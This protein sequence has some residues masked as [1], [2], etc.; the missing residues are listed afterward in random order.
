M[1]KFE[2]MFEKINPDWTLDRKEQEKQ[3]LMRINALGK[4]G[5]EL[6]ET[7]TFAFGA[8]F[9]RELTEKK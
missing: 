5:W 6:V 2:Y 1:K 7:N 9:K 8:L 4:E 3:L